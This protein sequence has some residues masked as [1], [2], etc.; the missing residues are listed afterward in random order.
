MVANENDL[1]LTRRF[2]TAYAPDASAGLL[3]GSRSRGSANATSDYDVVVLSRHLEEGAR[4]EMVRFDAAYFEVFVHDLGTLAYF[5][6]EVERPSAKPVLAA[7]I[8]EGVPV[9]MNDVELL[10]EARRIA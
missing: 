1:E 4:R 6:R 10:D 3:A 8:V 9:L 7:M 5:C 2:V